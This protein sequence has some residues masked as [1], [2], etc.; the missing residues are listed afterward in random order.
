MYNVLLVDDEAS[1][2][3]WL[4][5]NIP[6]S[7]LGVDSVRTAS[8]G[9]QALEFLS[10]VPADLLITDIRMPRMDGLT[11]LRT[12]RA[13]YPDMHCILLTAFGEFEYA[14]EAMKLGVDNYLL[15]P[16]QLQEL[17]ETIET[18]LDNI[19]TMRKNE[20]T[21][22]RENILRRWV[23]GT[24]SRDELGERA[25]Y[26]D[27]NIYQACYCAIAIR[28]TDPAVSL[29]AFFQ[30]C[31]SFFPAGLESSFVWDNSGHF[32]ILTGGSD[33]PEHLL[34]EALCSAAERFSISDKIYAAVGVSV[35][36]CM[37]LHISFEEACGALDA[38]PDATGVVRCSSLSQTAPVCIAEPADPDLS[39]LVRRAI[40]YIHEHYGD[41]VSIKEFCALLNVNAAY[42]GYLFKKET[43]T[44]FNSYLNDYRIQKAVELLCGTGKKINDIAAMTGYTTTSHFISTFRKKT[45]LS[46]LKYREI[47]GGRT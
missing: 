23:T 41:G 10:R 8:D 36:D 25:I 45:G 5:D 26:T 19:Y 20:S 42:L 37:D 30:A 32:I 12:A 15:K 39:P 22:F 47:H 17:T 29:H 34:A 21:L 43:G 31:A 24:I 38:A 44:Y 4:S 6:W 7:N 18:A 9:I 35:S 1:I 11:L 46:P 28:K 14:L 16:I 27:I 13:I 2:T 33:I 3:N 40:S